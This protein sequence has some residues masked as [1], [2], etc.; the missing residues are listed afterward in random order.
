MKYLLS[1]FLVKSLKCFSINKVNFQVSSNVWWSFLVRGFADR[2]PGLDITCCQQPIHKNFHNNVQNQTLMRMRFPF[3]EFP[4]TKTFPG[5]FPENAISWVLNSFPSFQTSA[6][7][8]WFPQFSFSLFRS[9]LLPGLFPDSRLE[10]RLHPPSHLH[11][12]AWDHKP[13]IAF[14]IC[15]QCHCIHLQHH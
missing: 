2:V 10:E 13:I 9:R 5:P 3:Y 6:F 11:S 12:R 4:G 15:P 8:S 1:L 14:R 7:Y